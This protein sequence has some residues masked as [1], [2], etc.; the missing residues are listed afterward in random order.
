MARSLPEWMGKTDDTKVPPHVRLRIFRR[1]DGVCHLTGFKIQTGD[2]WQLDHKK[3]LVEGGRHAESNLFPTLVEP[4]K[5]KSAQEVGRRAKADA[6]A[7][8][9]LG[10]RDPRQEIPSAP[11]KK[12]EKVKKNLSPLGIPRPMFV[13]Q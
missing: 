5:A 4:H 3:P 2:A 7:M 9:N 13:D 8:R 10:I 11:M 12:P 1:E 6:A